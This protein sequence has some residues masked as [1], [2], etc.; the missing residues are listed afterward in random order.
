MKWVFIKL[1]WSDV[2]KALSA[3][4]AQSRCSVNYYENKEVHFYLGLSS[5]PM[6]KGGIFKKSRCKRISIWPLKRLVIL[7]FIVNLYYSP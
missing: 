5:L 6:W 1:K 4:Q 3:V 7:Y 2:V